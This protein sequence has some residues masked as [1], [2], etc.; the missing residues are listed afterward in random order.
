[1]VLTQQNIIFFST[2]KKQIKNV[3]FVISIK[4]SSLTKWWFAAPH[5]IQQR[6]VGCNILYWKQVRNLMK[7]SDTLL[8]VKKSIVLCLKLNDE[9]VFSRLD[10]G[11][12]SV[13]G[14]PTITIRL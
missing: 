14:E 12:Q 6:N 5:W 13:G 1:M 4:P 7:N 9:I 2:N 8:W 3:V 10:I 11:K